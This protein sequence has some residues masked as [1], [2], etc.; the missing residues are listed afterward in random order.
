MIG[1]F[2]DKSGGYDPGEF[3]NFGPVV[4]GVNILNLTVP[5]LDCANPGTFC[6]DSYDTLYARFRLFDSTT[7]PVVITHT[8]LARNGEVEDY[9]FANA[10]T[11][12]TVSDFSATYRP[13]RIVINWETA[14][15]LDTLGF[16]IL[17]STSLDG[18]RVA[19]QR[20]IDPQP[21][22]RWFWRNLRVC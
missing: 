20:S 10:P 21:G 13:I 14:L 3:I 4:P 17:R 19:N 15:E 5:V 22:P 2:V 11:A 1:D 8:G 12:V 7:L 6:F 16:N 9:R 18:E